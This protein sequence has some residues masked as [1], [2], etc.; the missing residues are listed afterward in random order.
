MIFALGGMSF[1]SKIA[2]SWSFRFTSV[3][4][5]FK[6]HRIDVFPKSWFVF[7]IKCFFIF[8]TKQ[9]NFTIIIGQR[10]PDTGTFTA[11]LPSIKM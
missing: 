11:K 7:D 8:T 3:F 4:L 1:L 10:F 5:V 9:C 2:K 6:M